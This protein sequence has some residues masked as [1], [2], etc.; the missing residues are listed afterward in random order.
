[1]DISADTLVSALRDGHIRV[2]K[3]RRAVC[4]VLAAADARHLSAA[5]ILER[6]SSLVGASIDRS[7][8]YRALDV[9]EDAGL[10][11]HVHLDH[12]PAVYHLADR[13]RHHHFAC[14]ACGRT[15]DLPA[16]EFAALSTLLADGH[17]IG[18]EGLHFSVT[19]RCSD[20]DP[21]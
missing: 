8:V 17:G 4:D 7:T 12:G 14:V 16:D 2:T 15:I 21:A 6:T 13:S 1:M 10:L 3:A 19:G 5:D 20:C 11:H 18:P 9:L